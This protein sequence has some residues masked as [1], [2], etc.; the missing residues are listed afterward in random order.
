M[1]SSRSADVSCSFVGVSSGLI[2]T[3]SCSLSLSRVSFSSLN[4][5]KIATRGEM[6][7]GSSVCLSG[8]PISMAALEGEE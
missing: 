4:C 7:S 6:S 8:D 2:S 5:L 1:R 3:I